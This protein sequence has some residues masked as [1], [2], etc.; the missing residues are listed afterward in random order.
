MSFLGGGS[1]PA[2]PEPPK[3]PAQTDEET[4]AAAAR[5][6]ERIRR[7]RGRRSTIATGGQG[8]TE[9]YAGGKKTLGE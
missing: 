4:R 2:I 8:A 6:R 1:T 9:E 3:I 5:E 7:A